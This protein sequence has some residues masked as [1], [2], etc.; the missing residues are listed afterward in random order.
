MEW[1][2]IE[3]APQDVKDMATVTGDN[4]K[5]GMLRWRLGLGSKHVYVFYVE[6]SSASPKVTKFLEL[7]EVT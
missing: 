4:Y 1:Q 2:K 5:A 7:A 3:E 6:G